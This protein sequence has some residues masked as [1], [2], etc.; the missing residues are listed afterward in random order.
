MPIPQQTKLKFIHKIILL[1]ALQVT[2]IL[3]SSLIIIHFESQTSLTGSMVNI[4]G[5]NRI[6]TSMV[7]VGLYDMMVYQNSPDNVYNSLDRLHDNLM[8]LKTGGTHEDITIPPLP[9]QFMD[10]WQFVYDRFIQYE[11]EV[12]NVLDL[13][14]NDTMSIDSF[15]ALQEIGLH[16]VADSDMLTD[17]IGHTVDLMTNQLILLQMLLGIVDI[18]IILFLLFLIVRIF[19]SHTEE[20]IQTEKFAV[21]GKLSSAIAHDLRNPLG[22][23]RN[24]TL[25]LEKHD[26]SA[27]V[28]RELARI[29]RSIKRMA[30]QIEGVLNYVRT[31]P[32]VA[33]P[34]SLQEMLNSVLS[35]MDIHDNVEVHL[36]SSDITFTCDHMKLEFVFANLLLNA[37]QSI[38][39][40]KGHIEVRFTTDDGTI[41][42][43]FQNSGA[44]IPDDM[45]SKI[46]EPL[47]TTKMEG[48][49]LGLTSCKNIINIH[50]GTITAHN[51]P[52]VFT[53]QLPLR[54]E[55]G[56]D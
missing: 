17:K 3:A 30:H 8:L 9:E 47:F 31:V 18:T 28:T 54:T 27:P 16:M 5:K 7:H 38:G 24:S 39:P 20:Q 33:E 32:F 45:L 44:P 19:R 13:Y 14:T 4:A 50:G 2:L 29:N 43:E 22:T 52:V 21:L 37:L 34:A 56:N 23:I 11:G 26:N 40:N 10:D 12:L 49:G 51:D 46:F 36:P 53:L 25:L 6:L 35:T 55:L 15:A 48:T 41:T 42:I 1:V